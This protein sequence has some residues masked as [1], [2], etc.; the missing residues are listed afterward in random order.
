[1]HLAAEQERCETYGAGTV[2]VAKTTA[3]DELMTI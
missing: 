1:M 3:I 2:S